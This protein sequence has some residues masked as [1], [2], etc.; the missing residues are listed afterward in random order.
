MSECFRVGGLIAAAVLGVS[1]SV[2]MGTILVQNNASC[3]RLPSIND[4]SV[5]PTIG[6]QAN[7]EN[8]VGRHGYSQIDFDFGGGLITS[9]TH[10]CVGPRFPEAFDDAAGGV[11][12]ALASGEAITVTSDTLP[13]GTAVEFTLCFSITSEVKGKV[14]GG[15]GGNNFSQ[16]NFTVR[17]G[18]ILPTTDIIGGRHETT[19]DWASTFGTQD[20]AGETGSSVTIQKTLVYPGKV[21]ETLYL[22]ISASSVTMAKAISA[23]PGTYPIADGSSGFA[24]TFGVGSITAGAHLQWR[25]EN[26]MGSCADTTD[27][28]PDNP[29]PAAPTV[30][31]F[32]ACA[33]AVAHRRRA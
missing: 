9:R 17:Y 18:K 23:G 11:G 27:L 19:P 14:E 32:G 21:G 24:M 31:V 29:V 3:Q 20:F 16:N 2:A 12:S 25:G 7:L 26:W 4:S 6:F 1:P 15:A 33:M 10:G 28:V 5:L 8:Q 22:L 13:I 30:A